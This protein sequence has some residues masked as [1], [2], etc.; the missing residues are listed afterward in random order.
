[1]HVLA[2]RFT[3]ILGPDSP[4]WLPPVLIALAA[5]MLLGGAV[6]VWRRIADDRR[7]MANWPSRGAYRWQPDWDVRRFHRALL[8]WLKTEDWRIVAATAIDEARLRLI[9]CRGRHRLPMLLLRP[10]LLPAQADMEQLHAFQVQDAAYRALL[11]SDLPSDQRPVP[12]EDGTYILRL[13]YDALPYLNEDI[14]IAFAQ[15]EFSAAPEG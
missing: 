8:T 3:M 6:H 7:M 9:I 1:M 15:A 14:D 12:A 4:R 5:V 11:V 13:N 2:G 10:G